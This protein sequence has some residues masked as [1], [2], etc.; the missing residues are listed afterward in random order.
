MAVEI[1]MSKLLIGVIVINGK[2]QNVEYEG[3]PIVCYQCGK[4]GHLKEKCPEKSSE[5]NNATK[6]E[7]NHSLNPQQVEPC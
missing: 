2:A 6:P 5:K 4:V 1:D 3:I 7:S